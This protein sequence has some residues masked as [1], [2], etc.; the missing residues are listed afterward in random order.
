MPTFFL[1]F[2]GGH[3]YFLSNKNN[4]DYCL[5]ALIKNFMKSKCTLLQT[6]NDVLGNRIKSRYLIVYMD[7]KKLISLLH[8]D[9]GMNAEN[10][11]VKDQD[12]NFL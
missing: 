6:E 8:N 10:I 3:R 11:T 4:F 7:T 2:A 1:C 9:I 5:D 12:G